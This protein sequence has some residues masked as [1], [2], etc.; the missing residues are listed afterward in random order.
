MKNTKDNFYLRAFYKNNNKP[1]TNGYNILTSDEMMQ[2]Q[3]TVERLCTTRS[4]KFLS[5][6]LWQL[7][8]GKTSPPIFVWDDTSPDH[9]NYLYFSACEAYRTNKNS[10]NKFPLRI[11]LYFDGLKCLGEPIY[12]IFSRMENNE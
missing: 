11:L 12:F 4:G 2:L 9:E 6:E 7:V 8:T 5:Y 10:K 1:V 3:K